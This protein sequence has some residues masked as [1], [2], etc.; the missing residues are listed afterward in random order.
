MAKRT[1]SDKILK[2]EAFEIASSP[3][4]DGCQRW[5]SSMVYKFFDAKSA[6]SG[7]KKWN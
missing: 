7:I 3:N 2:D 1:Q 5:L 4:N 6:G